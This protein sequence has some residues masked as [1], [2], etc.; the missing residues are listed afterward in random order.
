V[1]PGKHAGSPEN[2]FADIRFTDGGHKEFTWPYPADTSLQA[3][4]T[5]NWWSG[6]EGLEAGGGESL[7]EGLEKEVGVF[8]LEY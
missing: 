1:R 8:G 2:F 5:L 7:V 4:Y 3:L 6:T